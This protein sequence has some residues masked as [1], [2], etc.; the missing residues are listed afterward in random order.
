MIDRLV[1]H[2]EVVS[3][4]GDCYRLKDRD[5]GRVPLPPGRTG[6]CPSCGGLF[7]CRGKQTVLVV[8]DGPFT[9]TGYSY[10]VRTFLTNSLGSGLVG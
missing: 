4:K 10:W 9:P 8:V 3:M 6:G 7:G 2:A 1:H 5:L